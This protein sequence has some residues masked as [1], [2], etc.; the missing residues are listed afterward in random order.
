MSRGP[1]KKRRGL[2]FGCVGAITGIT[3]QSQ[4][5]KSLSGLFVWPGDRSFDRRDRSFAYRI[6]VGTFVCPLTSPYFS[7][8]MYDDASQPEGIAPCPGALYSLPT[9]FIIIVDIPLLYYSH[10]VV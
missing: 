2:S 5:T 3:E 8:Q 4:R 7:H 10:S 9:L 6:W 1:R